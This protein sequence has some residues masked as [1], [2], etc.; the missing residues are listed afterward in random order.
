MF[1]YIPSGNAISGRRR[2]WVPL[3]VVAFTL[4]WVLVAVAVSREL[5]DQERLPSGAVVEV[6]RAEVTD[7]AGW[8]LNTA[9]TDPAQ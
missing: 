6:G 1:D 9:E 2:L 3:G 4:V 8:T 5:P 7:L